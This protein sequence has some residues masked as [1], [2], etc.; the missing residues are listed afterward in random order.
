MYAEITHPNATDA[1]DYLSLQVHPNNC[2]LNTPNQTPPIGALLRSRRISN[3]LRARV[4]SLECNEC[5]VRFTHD[6]FLQSMLPVEL[7]VCMLD[8][9][10]S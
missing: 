9:S 6:R 8:S 4:T 1:E 3:G 2:R 10:R 5:S 7:Y